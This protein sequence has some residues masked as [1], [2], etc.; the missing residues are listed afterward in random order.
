MDAARHDPRSGPEAM[1]AASV[2]TAVI[3]RHDRI[4]RRGREHRTGTV[5]NVRSTSDRYRRASTNRSLPFCSTG[6]DLALPDKELSNRF[7]LKLLRNTRNARRSPGCRTAH[8]NPGQYGRLADRLACAGVLGAVGLGDRRAEPGRDGERRLARGRRRLRLPDRLPLL[9]PLHRRAGAAARP[10]APDAGRAPQRRA[11]LRP[12][13]QV[14]AVRPPLRRHRRRRAA[15]RARA[16]R[17]DGLPAGHALDP[18][19]RG[20]RRRGAG[21]HGPV[22]LH[23]ARRPL[24]RR[25]D[26]AGDGRRCRA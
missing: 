4:A 15:G 19:R 1:H 18:G 10:G 12:D 23:P 11:R 6:S 21:L 3:A 17:A 20:L 9:Q 8:P 7:P 14:R 2:R 24:A 5:Q 25:D 13:Q 16:G 22:H 26:Q